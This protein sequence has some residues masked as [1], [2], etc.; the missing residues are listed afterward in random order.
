MENNNTNEKTMGARIAEFRRR[1]SLTQEQL[2]DA[3]NVTFQAVSKWENDVSCPDVLLLPVLADQLGVSLDELFGRP[4]PE[5]PAAGPVPRE[6]P[7]VVIG[8]LPWP[9][10]SDLHAVVYLGHRLLTQAQVRRHSHELQLLRVHIEGDVGGVTSDYGVEV[11]GSVNGD[12]N[13]GDSVHCADVA[14]SVEAGDGVTCGAVGQNLNAGD[15]V[16]CG[17]VGGSVSAGDGVTCTDVQGNVTA[18]DSVR[19]GNV[20]G[21]VRCDD[22]VQCGSV[23]GSV[24]CDSLHCTGLGRE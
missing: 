20:G 9:D 2:A 10:N 3:L 8:D 5:A 22:R 19:C 7:Q 18:G 17:S 6:E 12:V 13:A 1:R 23:A 11:S 24:N 21:S 15:S 4:A 16:S 14:G